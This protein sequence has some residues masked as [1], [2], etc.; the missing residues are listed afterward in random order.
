VNIGAH[1]PADSPSIVVAFPAAWPGPPYYENQQRERN[2]RFEQQ[3]EE[4]IH[5]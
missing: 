3:Q 1:A 2:G 4:T 5:G